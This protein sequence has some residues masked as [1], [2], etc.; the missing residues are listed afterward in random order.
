MKSLKI[1]V[2]KQNKKPINVTVK[3]KKSLKKIKL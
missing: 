3:K 1:V 2:Q